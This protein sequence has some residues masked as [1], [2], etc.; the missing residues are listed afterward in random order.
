M[1]TTD[2]R[3]G[4]LSDAAPL[5]LLSPDARPIAGK[6]IAKKRTRVLGSRHLKAVMRWSTWSRRHASQT[7]RFVPTVR[8]ASNGNVRLFLLVGKAP[9]PRHRF[10]LT[11]RAIGQR[12]AAG[13]RLFNHPTQYSTTGPSDTIILKDREGQS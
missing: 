4:L 6:R 8:F 10:H 11:M 7:G 13:I 1:P 9:A 5:E 3:K 12:H 2:Q